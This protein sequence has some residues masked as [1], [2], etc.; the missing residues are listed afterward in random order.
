[1]HI[2]LLDHRGQRLLGGASRFQ[3]G[4]E[5]AAFAQPRDLQVDAACARVPGAL[6][7]AVAVD[8]APGVSIAMRRTG[9]GLDLRLHQPVGGKRQHLTHQVAIGA[10]LDQF[11]QRHSVVGHRHLRLLGSSSQLEP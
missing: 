10:L 1:V 5:V 4:R 9:A 7:V 3:K 6:A 8:E 11:D 2:R